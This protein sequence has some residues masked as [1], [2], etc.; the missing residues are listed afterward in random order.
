MM[1]TSVNVLNLVTK[2]WFFARFKPFTAMTCS[3]SITSS[4]EAYQL[5]NS[6]TL[7]A[8]DVL[9]TS[10]YS[11]SRKQAFI[12]DYCVLKVILYKLLIDSFRLRLN[13]DSLLE[14]S[15]T[16]MSDSQEYDTDEEQS[17]NSQRKKEK[18]KKT[19]AKPVKRE[20]IYKKQWET[21]SWAKGTIDIM[22]NNIT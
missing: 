10:R 14:R 1:R 15:R 9:C 8:I 2:I 20:Y 5:T 12:L 21:Q 17:N 3:S 4:S 13:I 19:K 18:S 7:N 16:K 6:V 11:G 22:I